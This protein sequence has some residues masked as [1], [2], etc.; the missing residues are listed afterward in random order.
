MPQKELN[1]FLDEMLH[2]R[3][4]R[5]VLAEHHQCLHNYHYKPESRPPNR[6]GWLAGV[7]VPVSLALTSLPRLS[8]PLSSEGIINLKCDPEAVV[9]ESFEIAQNMCFNKYGVHVELKMVSTSTPR[10][11]AFIEVVPR[12]GGGE[13]QSSRAA[14]QQ[15]SRA[16][17]QQ[18]AE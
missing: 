5:R 14:E 11:F 10:P 3:I 2:S 17:E 18:L 6:M 1:K 15:S 8:D 9:R 4:G 7:T 13:Q 12:G 16:A